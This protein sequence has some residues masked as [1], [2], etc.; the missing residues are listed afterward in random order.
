[1]EKRDLRGI[2]KP[3]GR[4]K[5]YREPRSRATL[6][7]TTRVL[8][9]VDMVAVGMGMSRTEVVEDALRMWLEKIGGLADYREAE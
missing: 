6:D 1:M 4:P 9:D 5:V 2:G 7:I 3:M 8:H